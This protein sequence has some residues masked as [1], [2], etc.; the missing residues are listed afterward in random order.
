MTTA[1][2]TKPAPR[3]HGAARTSALTTFVVAETHL[4]APPLAPE[5]PLHLARY[6]RDIFVEAD[7]LMDGRLGSR[8]YWAFAWPGGQ[9][10]A[11]YILDHPELIAGKR[12]LDVGAGSAIGAIAALKAGARSALAADID[13]LADVAAG[14]NARAN[15]VEMATTTADLLGIEPDCDVLL[16]GDLVYEPDLQIRVGALLDAAIAQGIPVLYADRTSARRPRRDF[17]LL[18]E[19]E[20]PLTPPLVDN[21]IERARIW[22]LV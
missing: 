19:Y 1:E 5:I 21:F 4:V 14:L 12:I 16:I 11:R 9:A 17:T 20:A 15:G 13:P 8:P 6:A 2:L 7:L 3:A 18:A 10:L 22:Q